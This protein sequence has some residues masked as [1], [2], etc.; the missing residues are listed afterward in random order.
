MIPVETISE[1]GGGEIKRAV[2][3][4][5]QVPY[6]WYIVWTFVNATMYLHPTQ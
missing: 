4:W 2:R 5:V 6:I 3:G 1:I